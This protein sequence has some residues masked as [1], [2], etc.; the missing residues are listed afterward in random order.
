MSLF[1]RSFLGLLLSIPLVG[2]GLV[3]VVDVAVLAL[4][5]PGVKPE[6]SVKLS[7]YSLSPGS[8]QNATELLLAAVPP[9]EGSVHFT[10]RVEWTGLSNMKQSVLSVNQSMSAITDFSFLF[11]WWSETNERYEVLIRLPFAD[12]YS[13]E[14]WTPGFATNIR[15]CFEKDEIAFGD[16]AF[17]VDRKTTLRVLKS[18]GFIDEEKTRKAYTL[19]EKLLVA[20][21]KPEKTQDPCNERSVPAEE[22][23]PE[24]EDCDPADEQC[25]T[26]GT[27]DG[28]RS[29]QYSYREF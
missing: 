9:E 8:E 26:T 5:A 6:Q 7:G 18:S 1:N 16:E 20:E 24:F 28:D 23:P 2:C 15:I 25:W 21:Q 11:L 4:G 27:Q 29:R 12:I 22:T 13:V 14:L 3:S 19:L 17:A 10:G